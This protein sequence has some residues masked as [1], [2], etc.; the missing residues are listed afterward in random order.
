[1]LLRELSVAQSTTTDSRVVT[2]TVVSVSSF[3]YEVMVGSDVTDGPIILSPLA[4]WA[5]I[6]A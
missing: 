5:A 2:F 4:M 6:P 3:T 1:M